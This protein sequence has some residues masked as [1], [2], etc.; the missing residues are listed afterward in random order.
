M[1]QELIDA[2]FSEQ[3]IERRIGE[4]ET[5]EEIWREAARDGF[6]EQ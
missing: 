5:I 4:G 6:F 2:G 3:E 1:Y